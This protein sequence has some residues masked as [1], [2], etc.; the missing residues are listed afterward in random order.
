[1]RD[2]RGMLAPRSPLPERRTTVKSF[3]PENSAFLSDASGAALV[4]DET[5][6]AGW[7]NVDHSMHI[8]GYSALTSFFF[9]RPQLIKI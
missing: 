8:V 6:Y 9:S 7:Q 2:Y 5:N 3:F 4:V 1:M